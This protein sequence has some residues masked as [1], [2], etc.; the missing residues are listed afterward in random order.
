MSIP[1]NR[2]PKQEQERVRQELEKLFASGLV[3]SFDTEKMFAAIFAEK[4]GEDIAC[5]LD[6]TPLRRMEVSFEE[7]GCGYGLRMVIKVTERADAQASSYLQIERE[8]I[9]SCFSEETCKAAKD[10]R[11]SYI[12]YGR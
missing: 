7:A 11:V 10:K 8:L 6:E 4:K 9:Y 1:M 2:M 5:S 12:E 3:Q